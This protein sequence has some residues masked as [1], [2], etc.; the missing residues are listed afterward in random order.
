MS[1]Y[2]NIKKLI[3]PFECIEVVYTHLRRA[4][5]QR[6]EGVALFAGKETGDDFHVEN[7]VVPKQQAMRLESGLLYAVGSDEL[8]RLNVWLYENKKSL[9][10]Q[11]HSH[12]TEAYHSDTDD[13]FPIVATVG[14]FSIVVPDFAMGPIDI[15]L[16]AV[17]RLSSKSIWVELN[18]KEKRTLIDLRA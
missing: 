7:T 2:L 12:P 8:H 16:W 6:V 18:E 9:I 4:G 13:A 15:D 3:I 17:Y 11:I 14:G 5:N 1:G 10:A